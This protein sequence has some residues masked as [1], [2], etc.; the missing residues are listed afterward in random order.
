MADTE[1]PLCDDGSQF[2]TDMSIP[3]EPQY[4]CSVC[5]TFSFDRGCRTRLKDLRAQEP[6]RRRQLRFAIRRR[7]EA[8]NP[9]FLNPNIIAEIMTDNQAPSADLIPGLALED[10]AARSKES[11]FTTIDFDLRRYPLFWVDS[12][13]A[14]AN[15]LAVLESDRAIRIVTRNGD[16]VSLFA[17]PRSA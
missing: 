11:P 10:I 16:I 15:V 1:C 8:D 14:L 2:T 12:R 5:G 13:Q 9:L 7:T 6:A 3:S 4:T 17:V